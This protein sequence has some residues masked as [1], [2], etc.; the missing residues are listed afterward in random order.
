MSG[1]MERVKASRRLP[2]PEVRRAIR[3]SARVSQQDLADELGVHRCMVAR[4][5]SGVR[6]PSGRVL[7]DYVRLL[8]ELREA[9]AA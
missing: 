2:P 1:L 7:L 8:D 5:E 4:Y 6:R 3:R 9:V